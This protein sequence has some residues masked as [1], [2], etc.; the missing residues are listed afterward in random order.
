MVLACLTMLMIALTLMLSFSLNNAIH[1]KIRIQMHAD[2]QAYSVAVLEA[3][4]FNTLAY[5]N[6][7]IAAALVAQMSLH[8][9]MAIA[10]EA[11]S[12][13]KGFSVAFSQVSAME[14]LECAATE[15]PSHCAHGAD[16]NQISNKHSN[17]A[18]EITNGLD[19]QK[20]N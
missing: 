9:W 12:L 19:E 16:A 15:D 10:S 11:V 3:R 18:K 20:F 2:A 8:A 1:E 17:K 13:H 4:T 5:T 7:A 14:Y 6:R